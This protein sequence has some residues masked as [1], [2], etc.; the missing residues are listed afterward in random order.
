MA[1]D[2]E[3]AYA[4]P[5]SHLKNLVEGLAKTHERG[6]RYPIPSFLR[7]RPEVGLAFPLTDV[8]KT[9]GE[10]KQLLDEG[11]GVRPTPDEVVVL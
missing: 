6:I 11:Q 5:G 10:K 3:A 9:T 4:L 8:F 1:Q 7:Y 2:H